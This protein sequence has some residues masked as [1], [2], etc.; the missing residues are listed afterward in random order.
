MK[1]TQIRFGVV[2]RHCCKGRNFG[3]LEDLMF[4]SIERIQKLCRFSIRQ[5]QVARSVRNG[6]PKMFYKPQTLVREIPDAY[7]F[8]QLPIA[9]SHALLHRAF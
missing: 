1:C 6:L 9:S 2:C 7:F 8:L 3:H 5:R 4:M